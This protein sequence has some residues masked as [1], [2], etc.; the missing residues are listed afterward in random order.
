MV[1][2]D[3]LSAPLFVDPGVVGLL[4]LC[5]AAISVVFLWV[6]LQHRDRPG[7]RGFIVLV[8]G[9]TVWS[10]AIGVDKFF[11]GLAPS[12]AAFNLVYLGG[13]ITSVGWFLL[14][15]EFT[16]LHRTSR[17]LIG[18][19]VAVI[20]A[21]QVLF[22]TNP[23]HELVLRPGTVVENASLDT[24]Y[25]PAF[26]PAIGAFYLLI[27]IGT[28]L[29]LR[30]AA[31]TTGVRRTQNVVLSLAAI[32]P[33]VASVVTVFDLAFAPYDVTPFGFL[34]AE[35][36]FAWVLF[37]LQLFGVVSAGRRAAVDELPDAVL[38]L[39]AEDCI[40]DANAAATD[41]FGV[42]D[43][44]VGRPIVEALKWH[45]EIAR[46]LESGATPDVDGSEVT[47]ELDGEQRHVTLVTSDFET[48]A[49]DGSGRILVVR[50]VTERKR[51]ERQLQA[52]QRELDRLR[53]VLTGMLQE[54][55][56][57]SLSI[58]ERDARSLRDRFDDGRRAMAQAVLDQVA[59]LQEVSGKV[60]AISWLSERRETADHDLVAIVEEAAAEY[61]ERFPAATIEVDV[62]DRPTVHASDGLDVAVE[63]LIENAV[64]HGGDAPTV[65][66]IVE[67]TDDGPRL[68]VADDGPGIPEEE[69]EVL[70]RETETKLSH[71]TGIGLWLVKLVV[72]HSNGTLSIDADE[73]G[74]TV[75]LEFPAAGQASGWR[76]EPVP[77]EPT[78]DGSVV[79]GDGSTVV[80]PGSQPDDTSTPD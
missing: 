16:G 58:L 77:V 31:R 36:F 50:D 5:N 52:R 43:R 26:Y 73:T 39:D 4:D 3:A 24:V 45:P 65:H 38:T 11:W 15:I 22:W 1:T 14:T 74:T 47:V 60:M 2:A 21:G 57:R 35:V 7:A 37:R 29:L 44:D 62:R 41:R 64:V 59:E 42:D 17:R 76:P 54:D 33:V 48:R 51:R 30:S 75:T 49:G 56:R 46:C 18:G 13:Q 25:G 55:L 20:L 12:V 61:G 69:V 72:D 10:L 66:V 27:L 8:A 23:F 71:G 19:F 68:R 78:S 28:G 80:P 9:I 6:G 79:A 70:E 53:R 67:A 34:F 63:N 40:V 32:P